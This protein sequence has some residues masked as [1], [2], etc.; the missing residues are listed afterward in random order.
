M[1]SGNLEEF[2]LKIIFRSFCVYVCL[3]VTEINLFIETYFL[4]LKCLTQIHRSLAQ[5]PSLT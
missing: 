4:I 3:C 5:N 2:F 1:M